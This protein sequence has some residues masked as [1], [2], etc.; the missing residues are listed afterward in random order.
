MSQELAWYLHSTLEAFRAK[1]DNDRDESKKIHLS[2][3]RGTV[4]LVLSKKPLRSLAFGC[5]AFVG[6]QTT[7]VAFFV[8][9]LT[10]IGYGSIEAGAI[11]SIATAVAIPG[12]I[13]WGWLSSWFV[14]P[15]A[16]LGILALL[17]FV[18]LG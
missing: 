3:F 6:L 2:D 5:F 9:Y 17:M 8:I 18:A 12:R 13:F 11:F 16:M 10:D 4:T 15:R 1:F 14:Q 7:F